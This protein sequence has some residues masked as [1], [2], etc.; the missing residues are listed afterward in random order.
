MPGRTASDLRPWW[1][2]PSLT[3]RVPRVPLAMT[4]PP[5]PDITCT[6]SHCCWLC[7]RNCP[8]PGRIRHLQGPF[9]TLSEILW[10][11]GPGLA[12]GSRPPDQSGQTHT[13]PGDPHLDE[14]GIGGCEHG[15]F[16][17]R[18]RSSY[19]AWKE[20]SEH[21]VSPR[22]PRL[23]PSQPEL[24]TRAVGLRGRGPAKPIFKYD[25]EGP[26]CEEAVDS[27]PAR[28]RRLRCLA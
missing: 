21:T 8:Y 5:A 14:A 12:A 11:V 13:T 22:S 16:P 25:V 4:A 7:V 19:H 6:K 28:T 17:S 15:G 23:R 2:V 1:S 10:L 20:G 27:C 9:R 18:C 26:R 24:V 3:T